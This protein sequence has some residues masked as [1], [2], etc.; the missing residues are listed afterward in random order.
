MI[1]VVASRIRILIA[2][3]R[4]QKKSHNRSVKL[5]SLLKLVSPIKFLPDEVKSQ[6]KIYDLFTHVKAKTKDGGW[7]LGAGC[8]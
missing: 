2:S 6:C 7:L 1:E 5:C 8:W 4:E 3:F